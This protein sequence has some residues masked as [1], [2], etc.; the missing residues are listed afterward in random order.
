MT[1]KSIRNLKDLQFELKKLTAA[2]SKVWHAEMKS[3]SLFS[4]YCNLAHD[5]SQ[6]VPLN[7][8][9]FTIDFY[10]AVILF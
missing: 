4:L 9:S 6:Y 10:I 1:H 5:Q 2:I 7:S 8:T 3:F